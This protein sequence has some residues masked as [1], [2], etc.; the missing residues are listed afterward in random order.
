M[1]LSNRR[2]AK[3]LIP[4]FAFPKVSQSHALGHRIRLHLSEAEGRNFLISRERI[5]RV[6]TH[7]KDNS[8]EVLDSLILGFTSSEAISSQA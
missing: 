2:F 6:E 5:K 1:T 3:T 7:I 8:S 4:Y